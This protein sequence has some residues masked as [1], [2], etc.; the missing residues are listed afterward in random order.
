MS[1][2][3]PEAKPTD[4]RRILLFRL[5]VL[6]IMAVYAG[7]L[8]YLQIL[9]GG[10]F[11]TQ[12][13]SISR[14]SSVL[15]A[16][17][18][19]IYD[20]GGNIPLVLNVDSFALD[21]IP[22]ELPAELRDTVFLK[23]AQITGRPVDELR[24]KIPASYYHLYQPVEVVG[25]VP[26]SVI[27]SVAERQDELPGVTW[28][29]KPKRSYLETGS[30]SHLI[31]YVGDITREELKLL[32]N[33]G[34]QVGD[35]IGKAGIEKQYDSILR[36]RDGREYRVVDVRGRKIAGAQP[37]V[38]PP[39]PGRNIVLTIDRR[40]QELSE[41]ALG[42]RMGSVVVLKPRTGEILAMVSY[43]WY[44]PNLFL[45][46]DGGQAY[47][48]LLNDPNKPLLN[49]AI[50]SAYPPASTFKVVVT[51]GILEENSF[52]T[53]K[54]ILCQGEIS[55]GDRVFRCWIR[56]P[57]HG[58]LD[59]KGALAQSC[60]IYFWTVARDHLGIERLVAYT[61]EFGL[62]NTSGIDLPGEISGFYPSPQWKERRYHEKW[63][64]GDTM[65]M[66][67][68]QGYLLVTPLQMA[69]MVAM[70]VNDGVVY[71]PHVLSEIRDPAT[72]AIIRTVAPEVLSQSRI[73]PETFRTVRE[74][75]R[76]VITE[77]T[78]RYP[79]NTKAVPVAGKTGTAEVGLADRWHS[80][81]ASYGPFGSES[82]DDAVVVV[83]MVEATNPWEW[84]APY[85]SNIIFQGIFANQT[86]EDAV[87]ALG[88]SYMIK[89]TERVE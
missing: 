11:R 76:A 84:W 75:M 7:R 20:R 34:Y 22:A 30:L 46:A 74:N 33:Q 4:P 58:A 49:R 44:N 86:Y 2:L 18:G 45:E 15:P 66:A 69:N 59:L 21:V 1:D 89:P 32:F 77:G 57:G 13:A 25:S 80:W 6:G 67:I 65:N 81:F 63:L 27:V 41:K 24:A 31:G 28:H 47:A 42:R 61:K 56:K 14:Q 37:S 87:Q 40:I 62:G 12:A 26:Y 88:L 19:E 17:R 82:S 3:I 36:G 5:L 8:F 38:D 83:V 50:Q 39:L 9:K 64:G 70:I 71:K 48:K 79:V 52:P 53:D 54:T 29:A 16:Q 85:A 51:T 35:V 23:L 78:A 10:E 60:D 68:G 55:Y 72:G 43:P 73:K